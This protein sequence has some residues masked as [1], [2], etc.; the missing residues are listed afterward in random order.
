MEALVLE[1]EH[2]KIQLYI[3]SRKFQTQY[4]VLKMI[5][6]SQIFGKN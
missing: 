4:L 5:K 6:H 1:I 3:K 2:E